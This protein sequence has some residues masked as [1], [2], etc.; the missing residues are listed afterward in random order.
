MGR[1]LLTLMVMV[2]LAG[3]SVSANAAIVTYNLTWPNEV[4][5]SGPTYGTVTLEEVD[6]N[7]KFTVATSQIGTTAS[8]NTV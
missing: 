2:L 4:L 1:K 5:P 3:I 6:G 7:V 8:P